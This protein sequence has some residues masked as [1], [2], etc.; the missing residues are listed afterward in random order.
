MG[1]IYKIT[2][3]VNQKS[4]IGLTTLTPKKRWEQHLQSANNPNSSSYTRRIKTK[5][6]I[7]D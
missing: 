5:R 2:N 4:Y 7:L 1:Y 3:L 6:T